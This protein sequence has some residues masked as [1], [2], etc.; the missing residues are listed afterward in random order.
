MTP[1]PMPPSPATIFEM[2]S[3]YQQTAA[4]SAAIE[5]SLFTAIAEGNTTVAAMAQRCA[6]SE[7]GIRILCDYLTV[8]GLL[9]K[10]DGSYSLSPTAAVFL[11]QNSPAYLGGISG[12]LLHPFIRGGYQDLAQT[13]RR[14]HPPSDHN[15]VDAENPIWVYFA[16]CMA[17]MMHP[18]AMRMAQHLGLGERPAKILDVAAGHG[19]FGIA[20]AQQ[21]P[22][23]QIYALDWAPVLAVARENAQAA[24]V[25]DRYHTL[26]GSAFDVDLGS[27]YDVVLL[28][29]FL[30]HFDAATNI[31]LLKKL[32]AA[33][34]PG[35]RLFTLEFVPNEDR[36]SPPQ[37]ATFS[38]QMLTSTQQG[39]AYTYAQL[40]AML[41]AAGFA[42]SELHDLSP[43]MNSLV[44]SRA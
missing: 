27:G 34:V 13:V 18:V 19:L 32:H 17:P 44:I 6:A 39:D 36:V 41:D 1:A 30:H 5:L 40:A 37:A 7:R 35:G 11:N 20:C 24:G 14:G 31:T 15:S 28:T 26:P 3:A 8:H 21:A 22:A 25:A 33:L 2:L 9:A 23:A 10:S 29:N 16:R 38:L 42:H 43:L 12:F 4:L